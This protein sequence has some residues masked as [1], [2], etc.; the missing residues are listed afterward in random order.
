M[1]K[2]AGVELE[3][4]WPKMGIRD[5]LEVVKSI[6]DYQHSWSSFSF[7]QFGSLYFSEDVEDKAASFL[8]Y[9][10]GT[11]KLVVDERFVIGPCCGREF[12][13]DGRAEIDFDIGPCESCL[14]G[15][16]SLHAY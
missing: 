9:V 3:H 12:F 5:R 11:G 10:D 16:M 6:A 13:D 7:K 4:F 8:E 2:L 15:E 14:C 1:E